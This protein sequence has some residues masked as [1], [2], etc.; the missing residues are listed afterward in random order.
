MNLLNT[1]ESWRD[2]V[3]WINETVNKYG[4][5]N[6]TIPKENS[7]SGATM[8]R[9]YKRYIHSLVALNFT[10][11]YQNILDEHNTADFLIN[12]VNQNFIKYIPYAEGSKLDLFDLFTQIPELKRKH[13]IDHFYSLLFQDNIFN[14]K[15]KAL[16]FVLYFMT[17]FYNLNDLFNDYQRIFKERKKEKYKLWEKTAYFNQTVAEIYREDFFFTM[18]L[19]VLNLSISSKGKFTVKEIV[20]IYNGYLKEE[21]KPIMPVE[22]SNGEGGSRIK[23]AFSYK[24]LYDKQTKW[25]KD[26]GKK[27]SDW[28]GDSTWNR[29]V[30][31][32]LKLTTSRKLDQSVENF[33][34][35]KEIAH[36]NSN[37]IAS[38]LKL[39]IELFVININFDM[40]KDDLQAKDDNFMPTA[41]RKKDIHIH[42]AHTKNLSLHR[43]T[44]EFFY[45]KENEFHISQHERTLFQSER[46]E[47]WK[48][49]HYILNP[50]IPQLVNDIINE[51]DPDDTVDLDIEF[52]RILT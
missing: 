18:L 23:Y 42:K 44:D 46:D 9:F 22:E 20:D 21:T 6:A 7:K 40:V 41:I 8:E 38:A 45:Q 51:V 11:E 4:T 25:D 39:I 24:Y 52:V 27:T 13:R 48:K 31:G 28:F 50:K 17:S 34:I 33:M 43:I 35:P 49:S 14:V 16:K 3:F 26:I 29:R 30:D 10:D 32:E 15:S 47:N 1:A 2:N 36:L 5:R 12:S 37:E 19:E